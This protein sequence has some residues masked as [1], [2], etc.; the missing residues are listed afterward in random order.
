MYMD[1][2]GEWFEGIRSDADQRWASKEDAEKA[3]RSFRTRTD[4]LIMRRRVYIACPISN[5]DTLRG[6]ETREANLKRSVEA[7]DAIW[8]LGL[9]P[10]NPAFSV[11]HPNWEEVPYAIWTEIDKPWVLGSEAVYR[12]SGDSKGADEEVQLAYEADIPVFTTLESLAAYFGVS[13]RYRELL[14]EY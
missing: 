14:Y 10:L 1:K 9:A 11:F 3:I 8:K 6:V 12:V 2:V 7:F 5:G 4:S 13:E